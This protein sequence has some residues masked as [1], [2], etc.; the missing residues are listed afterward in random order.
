MTQHRLIKN[1]SATHNTYYPT[2]FSLEKRIVCGYN[3]PTVQ[4]GMTVVLSATITLHRAVG[5]W[6]TL[7]P[8]AILCFH[9]YF[10]G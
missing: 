1:Q 9:W 4:S 7:Q 6:R 10:N 2:H 8:A 5:C 3:K